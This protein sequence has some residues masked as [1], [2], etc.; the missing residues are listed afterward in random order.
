M[1]RLKWA[2]A[3]FFIGA[4]AAGA[5]QAI[6][7]RSGLGG[8]EGYGELSQLPNDDGSSSQLNLPFEINFFGNSFNTFFAN[9]N[10]NISFTSPLSS[11]TPS[12]FPITNQPVIAPFWA[13]VDTRG[14]GAVYTA[15]PNSDTLV[16]TWSQVGY[17][18]ERAD[19]LNDFQMTML[20]RAD[21][22]V[23]N[24]DIEFRYSALKWTTGD[25]SGGTNGLGGTAAQAGYD[26]GDGTNFF[27]LPGSFSS[28]VL[29]LANTSNVDLNTP[30]LW[31]TAIRNGQTSDGSSASAPLL[32][33]I[34]TAEGFQF[35]FNIDLDQ[36]IFI[37]PVVAVGYDY[38][39]SSG[40]NIRTALFPTVA[41]DTDGFSIYSLLTDALLG[42]ATPGTAFDFGPDGVSGFRLLGIDPIAALDPTNTTAFVT[43]LTFTG[44][45]QVSMSQNPITFDTNSNNIPEPSTTFLFLV[46][47]LAIGTMG[48]RRQKRIVKSLAL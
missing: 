16:V 24:F 7:L 1:R 37:D 41:G 21:T 11:Y 28:D 27:V 44:A 47:A 26:A 19:E 36:Q 48:T 17:Y 46:G 33:E 15:A 12:P 14:S 39:V 3:V 20:N 8:P 29:A 5:S 4:L 22:G 9:N 38:S 42:I 23:G 25:A 40:P 45:G 6:E 31:T 2:T 10:G 34:V 43:G 32:P 35:N 30:G 18:D 13:D